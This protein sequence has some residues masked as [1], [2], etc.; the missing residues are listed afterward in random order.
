MSDILKYAE[1]PRFDYISVTDWI[2]VADGVER[3]IGI[4]IRIGRGDILLT[5]TP[6]IDAI[7]MISH[8]RYTLREIY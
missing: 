4:V 5:Y 6:T 7:Q 8:S 2:A 3:D 1:V